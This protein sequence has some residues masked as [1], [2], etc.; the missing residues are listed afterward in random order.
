MQANN[1]TQ[2][3]A[4]I[5]TE[6]NFDNEVISIGLVVADTYFQPIESKYYIV[7]P[8]CN[9][10]AM[11]S[12]SLRLESLSVYMEALRYIV[13]DDITET[14]Q[15][16][17]IDSIFAYNATFDHSMLPELNDYNWFDI[18]KLAANK[19]YNRAIP[20]S[21]DCYKT[22]RLKRGYGVESMMRLLL[23]DQSYSEKHNALCDAI[24]ELKI[25]E[26][27]GIDISEYS[28]GRINDISKKTNPSVTVKRNT[29]KVDNKDTHLLSDEQELFIKKAIDGNNILVNACIGSG[30]T[31]SI[32]ALCNRLPANKKILYLTY[33]RLL[34]I[35]AK[36][37]IKNKNVTVTNYH[38][39]ASKSLINIGKR[40]NIND[41]INKFIILS[42]PIEKYDVLIIDEY[43]DIISEFVTM[44]ER[45]K[46]V[47]PYIQIIAVGDL[48]QK[49]YDNTTLD[50]TSFIN[51]Y[52]GD[53]IELSFTKCFRL[54]SELAEK[55]GRIWDKQILGV[56]NHCLVTE[57]DT[58]QIVE[59]ISRQNPGDILCL[60][61][62][63]GKLSEVLNELESKYPYKFNKK[64]VYASISDKD[65]LTVALPDE[66][67]AI[68]TTFD[69]SKGLERKIC[70]IFDY[71]E[72]YW[73]VRVDKSQTSFNILRN[74]FCVAASRGKE[75][76]IFVND[77]E[78]MLSEESLKTPTKKTTLNPSFNISD[79][80]DFKY[81]EDIEESFLLLHTDRIQVSDKSVISEVKTSDGLINLSPCIGHY[82]E[83]LF[84]DNYSIDVEIEKYLSVPEY[85]QRYA[86]KWETVIT[87]SVEKKVLFLV[88]MDTKQDR[89]YTQ[90]ETPFIL[91]NT[92]KKITERLS[93]RLSKKE[94]VQVDCHI[95]FYDDSFDHRYYATGLADVVKNNVVYELKFVSELSHI[96]FLQCACYMIALNLEKGI[97][98]NTKN[99]DIYEITIPDRIRF[100]DSVITT[101]TKH[102]IK[103]FNNPDFP[104]IQPISEKQTKESFLMRIIKKFIK[105]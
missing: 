17:R 82:Q 28:Y 30:K 18:M 93:T 96:H 27:L 2:R 79:M 19:N 62:R 14:L 50:V 83:I 43:Q 40:A 38:G 91:G 69:S 11:F 13:I 42:P 66:N 7:S 39:F 61:S 16:N 6:T 29:K 103:K 94:N 25:M 73:A 20:L 33:N 51:D 8:E 48:D 86:S 22:G 101:I 88:S 57:A 90:V 23:N 52:L 15:T 98:W 12:Y 72:S 105:K 54:S 46:S 89:Y 47:N 102:R 70:I 64:T 41:L 59:F 81:R 31:T 44:L 45:I 92:E 97:L 55:L 99:N 78:G 49:I 77:G 84:F 68:F 3:F 34:K 36:S 53:H 104:I 26:L 80:F 71:T 32:Q 21:A 74:I 35:D 5:D 60:G 1:F 87:E 58:V 95:P 63:N 56:N 37:K 10:P 75:Q 67:T 100:I 65:T 9:K 4:I 24:D 85:K 76:I